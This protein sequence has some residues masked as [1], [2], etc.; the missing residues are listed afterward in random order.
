MRFGCALIL[1]LHL[2]AGEVS[3]TATCPWEDKDGYTPVL[4]TV[5]AVAEQDVEITATIGKASARDRV[6][7]SPVAPVR[8]TLLLPS[9][10]GWGGSIDLRW[11]GRSDSERVHVGASG[12]R[13]FQVGLLDPDEQVALPALAKRIEAKAPTS[14]QSRGYSSSG[15]ERARR[16]GTDL[17]DRWQGYPAWLTLLTTPAGD[18]RLD[19]AQRRAIATWTTVGG[20]LFVTT[21]EQ[22]QAW[23]RLGVRAGLYRPDADEALLARLRHAAAEC[24]PS[25]HP[26]PGTGDVPVG[27]FMTLA[28]GFAVIVGPLNLWWVRRRGQPHLLLAT[29]PAISLVTCAGLLLTAFLAEGIGA[30]R[31][32]IQVAIIDQGRHQVAAFTGC[33]WFCGLPPGSIALDADDRLLPFDTQDYEGRWRRDAYELALDWTAGQRAEG[34]WLPA[35]VNRQLALTQV[36]PERRRVLVSAHPDGLRVQNGLDVAIARIVAIDAEGRRWSANDI[37][38]GGEAE[39]QR[40]TKNFDLIP[41]DLRSRVGIDAALALRI[42]TQRNTYTALV[43]APLLP[44]IGPEAQDAKPPVALVVGHT[45]LAIAD[46]PATPDTPLPRTDF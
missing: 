3:V 26:V 4:V 28:I 6:R 38:P 32:A 15:N 46:E 11:S 8:R 35:R 21:P 42:A 31:H 40:I 18:R 14:G 36:R 7:V 45:G 16:L 34:G 17:P 22:Q 41:A 2:A 23:E 13:D 20:A 30:R 19:D 39:A 9:N 44:L 10:T 12:H 37:P 29:V 27:W 5:E 1:L 24:T 33:T 25:E 43:A